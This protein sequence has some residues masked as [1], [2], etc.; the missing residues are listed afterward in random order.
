[1]KRHAFGWGS[2]VTVKNLLRQDA[3]GE[4]YRQVIERHYLLDQS[5][6]EIAEALGGTKGSVRAMC[7]RARKRLRE[8]MGRS[9]MY[10]SN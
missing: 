4:K 10:F 3:D 6:E 5:L 8:L 7:Y 1:M 9:S 2:C